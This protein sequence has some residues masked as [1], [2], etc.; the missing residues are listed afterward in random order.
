[1]FNASDC[2]IEVEW[3]GHAH[4]LEPYGSMISKPFLTINFKSS[5][6]AKLFVVKVPGCVS[7]HTLE[8]CSLFAESG[9]QKMTTN[10]TRW[11]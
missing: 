9:F 7:L 8:E 2:A 3:D 6:S 10:K 4:T 5:D 1:M 11:W